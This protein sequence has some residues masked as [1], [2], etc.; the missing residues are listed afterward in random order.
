MKKLVIFTVALLALFIS[1]V[2][3]GQA[4][5]K[6]AQ[7]KYDPKAKSLYGVSASQLNPETVKQLNDKNYQSIIT[8]DK[9]QKKIA[10]KD[11]FYVYFFSPLCPHCKRST[12]YVNDAFKTAGQVVYQYNVLE[13][14]SAFSTYGFDA[15]PTTI[16][17]KDG[18]IADKVVGEVS[19]SDTIIM[20]PA[21][22]E[23]W[24]ESHK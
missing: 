4:Q 9:L 2:L 1:I 20:T 19:G 21:N 24:I 8:S 5:D 7:N 3:I 15:T 11:T 10:N 12:P 13:D 22:F 18:E 6:K 16:Y 23:K 17:F 14:Q